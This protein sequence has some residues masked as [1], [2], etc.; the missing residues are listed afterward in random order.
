MIAREPQG[1]IQDPMSGLL[2]LLGIKGLAGNPNS[3]AGSIQPYLDVFPFLVNRQ[4]EVFFGAYNMAGNENTVHIPFSPDQEIGTTL[5]V[6]NATAFVNLLN[7]AIMFELA[8]TKSMAGATIDESAVSDHTDRTSPWVGS[9]GAPVYVKASMQHPLLLRHGDRLGAGV[10]GFQLNAA[11]AHTLTF[12][13]E[14][15]TLSV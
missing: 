5:L 1:P 8:I 9:W 3:L 15:L 4:P 7:P 6:L 14:Y 11:P 10:F 2:S 12:R 13:M